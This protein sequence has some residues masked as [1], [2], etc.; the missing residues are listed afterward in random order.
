MAQ[1]ENVYIDI[2]GVDGENRL[3]RISTNEPTLPKNIIYKE[4]AKTI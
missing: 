4:E 2:L 1:M 3:I